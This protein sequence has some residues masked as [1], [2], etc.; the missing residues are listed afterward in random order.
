MK[1]AYLPE[2]GRTNRTA[3]A[4]AGKGTP[5]LRVFEERDE[6]KGN[7]RS[8]LNELAREGA[9]RTLLEAL[10]SRLLAAS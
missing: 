10:D 5:M 7:V 8:A 2:L 1:G 4:D 6:A 3:L 9:R